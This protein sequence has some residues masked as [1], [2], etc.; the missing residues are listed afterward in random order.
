MPV[1][2]QSVVTVGSLN[3]DLGRIAT[4]MRDAHAAAAEFFTGVNELGI[5]GLEEVGFQTTPNPINKDGVK[6]SQA[7]LDQASFLNTMARVF[8]G[9]QPQ[10]QYN[11]DEATSPAR[12]GH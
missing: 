3:E 2:Y 9:L 4:Q 11:F 10:D 8:Y 6:D 5:V 12:G 7:F 1:G